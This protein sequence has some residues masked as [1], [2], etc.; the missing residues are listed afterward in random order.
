MNRVLMIGLVVLAALI[1]TGCAGGDEDDGSTDS[2]ES[3]ARQV[4]GDL[5]HGNTAAWQQHISP[6]ERRNAVRGDN[7]SGCDP[8]KA[9][10]SV[11][12]QYGSGKTEVR[13]VF[14]PACGTSPQGYPW[15][16]C[17]LILESLSDRLYLQYLSH[18]YS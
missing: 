13:V 8:D 18:C 15:S 9:L 17:Q 5:S 10:Y 12:P 16:A 7:L 14:D 4:I 1:L 6:D 3:F 2:A 11:N